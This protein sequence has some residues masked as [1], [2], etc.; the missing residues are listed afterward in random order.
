MSGERRYAAFI[1]YSHADEKLAAWLHR[2]LESY[3]IPSALVG[4]PGP[5]GPIKRRLGRMF[6]DRLEF[7]ASP[8][9]AADIR[10]ALDA[11]DALI[12][13]CSPKAAQSAYVNE[14]IR[15]FKSLGGGGRIMAAILSGEPNAAGKTI[16]GAA[17]SDAEECFPRALTS[18]LDANGAIGGLPEPDEP[19]AADF[20]EGKDE[21][22]AASLKLIAGLLDVG[23]DDLI[24]RERV[25]E[26][27]RRMFAIGLAGVFA[28]LAAVA[29]VQSVVA[30]TRERQA[31]AAELRTRNSL[32][33]ALLLQAESY[34]QTNQATRPLRYALLAAQATPANTGE[35]ERV[36][37]RILFEI[38]ESTPLHGGS[39][40]RALAYSPDGRTLAT[41]DAAGVVALL[42][43]AT[44]QRRG[45]W[46]GHGGAVTDLVFSRVGERLVTV[47]GDSVRVW[48]V[49]DAAPLY[50]HHAPRTERASFDSTATRVVF[51]WDNCGA[52]SIWDLTSSATLPLQVRRD[53]TREV[54]FLDGDRRVRT[55]SAD[56]RD[57]WDAATGRHVGTEPAVT[58]VLDSLRFDRPISADG[59]H[60][61]LVSAYDHVNRVWP[62][63]V[64]LDGEAIVARLLGHDGAITAVAFSPIGTQI[65]TAS[66]DGSVR[67][68]RGPSGRTRAL[69]QTPDADRVGDVAMIAGAIVT[70]HNSGAVRIWRM[71]EPN[72]RTFQACDSGAQ[73]LAPHPRG[74]ALLIACDSGDAIL[75]DIESGRE[76]RRVDHGAIVRQVALNN[77][78]ALALSASDDGVVKV[79][80]VNT[81]AE[82]AT[83]TM[84]EASIRMRGAVFSPDGA[85]VLA[86]TSEAAWFWD[87]STLTRSA[88][89]VVPDGVGVWDVAITPDGERVALGGNRG[90]VYFFNAET[91][92]RTH[93]TS[94]GTGQ[95]VRRVRFSNDGRRLFAA[96]MGGEAAVFDADTGRQIALL[97]GPRGEKHTSLAL[98][99]DGDRL[100]T[101]NF[102][103]EVR[104]IDVAPLVSR[105]DRLT[106]LVCTQF[107]L[108]RG[109]VFTADEL[110]LNSALATL[111]GEG[112]NLCTRQ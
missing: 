11:S 96:A 41:G 86:A 77:D 36:L 40:M 17:L 42:D 5:T 37:A 75:F 13:L 68:W 33:V 69:W 106:A 52:V 94:E 100:A 46:R 25:A 97:N 111:G 88:P 43:V 1:S 83:W 27:R 107:L 35:A 28:V 66:D 101:A 19:I 61:V 98:N 105:I 32:G 16:G 12:V 93:A 90:L 71:D 57:L 65:A 95:L 78:G 34:Y 47:G 76:L 91:R 67:L 84:P 31:N 103:G 109:A 87:L 50:H 102:D 18:Q 80:E 108:P 112:R 29:V 10:A 74:R 7:G 6:R 24:R 64:V 79:W 99:A 59:S 104:V 92:A 55:G 54:A 73:M 51:T 38:N 30:T 39:P 56:G 89:F 110:E 15:Y 3:S 4:Q 82:I 48:R 63:A 21:R 44:L 14:E 58:I 72:P 53:C 81:G 20:R 85:R 49:D 70:A 9:L 2:R 62:G 8:N 22:E 23:L 60:R 45:H 26:R